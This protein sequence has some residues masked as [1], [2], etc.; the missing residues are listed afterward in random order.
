[1]D[2]FTVFVVVAIE[3]EVLLGV[4]GFVLDICE[5]SAIYIFYKNV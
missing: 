5:D 4:C 1:M 3:V 2:F